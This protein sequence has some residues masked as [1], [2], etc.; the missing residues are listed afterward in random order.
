MP[1]PFTAA[2]SALVFKIKKKRKKG[3]VRSPKKEALSIIFK[4]EDAKSY[5]EKTLS[6]IS[7]FNSFF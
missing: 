1:A 2:E 6:S 4:F 7:C 5:K 3:P